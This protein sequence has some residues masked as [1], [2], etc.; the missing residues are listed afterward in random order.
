MVRVKFRLALKTILTVCIMAGIFYV[1]LLDRPTPAPDLKRNVNLC[2]KDNSSNVST[3]TEIDDNPHNYT[4]LI[5]NPEKCG[6]N[7]V[8][9]LVMVTSIP[10]NHAQRLAIRNTWGNESN[11][12]GTVIKTVFAVGMTS[13]ASVQRS[14]EQENSVYKDIIQENFIDSYRNL[15]IKTAM[16]LK[17]AS[18]FCPMAKFVLKAD[19][20]T[21]VNVFNLVKHLAGLNAT[22][23]RRFVT[24]RVYTGGKPVRKTYMVHEKRWCL[25]RKDYPRDT[26]PRYPGGYAYVISNDITRLIYEVSLTVQYLFIEDVN[27]GLCLEKLG[28]DP[29]HE[30]RIVF[31]REVHSCNDDKISSHWFKTP[32]AMVNEWRHLIS[33]C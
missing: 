11:V 22:Q 21:F 6:D 2:G 32:D 27:L 33:S 25:T 23:A 26:F 12:Q 13:D 10:R 4:F 15:T 18:G 19:D 29:V 7:D 31:W 5:N 16:C 1:Y 28:I 14:L 24:G 9:L 17:W 3:S 8:F 20:D 30:E